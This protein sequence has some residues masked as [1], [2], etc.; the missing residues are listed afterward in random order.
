MAADSLPLPV[1][2]PCMASAAACSGTPCMIPWCRTRTAMRSCKLPWA[3]ASIKM[4]L[5]VQQKR[6]SSKT[7]QSHRRGGGIL[8]NSQ[9][10]TPHPRCGSGPMHTC[11]ARCGSGGFAGGRRPSHPPC[12]RLFVSLRRASPGAC[13]MTSTTPRTPPC[14]DD[15]LP[16]ADIVVKGRRLEADGQA[17]RLERLRRSSTRQG[18]VNALYSCKTWPQHEEG[19]QRV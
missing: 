3:A 6:A 19:G 7:S 17:G 5:R 10:R 18:Q 16:S 11:R 14:S 15:P 1:L 2:P 9:A 4:Y 12:T 13:R 8:Y